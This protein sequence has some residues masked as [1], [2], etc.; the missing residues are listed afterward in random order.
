MRWA[1]E[2]ARPTRPTAGRGRG[3][4][5]ARWRSGLAWSGNGQV[6]A[7]VCA[8]EPRMCSERERVR[9]LTRGRSVQR[10]R[11]EKRSLLCQWALTQKRT[12]FGSRGASLL[13][14][15]QRDVAL[16]SL[17]ESELL[18]RGRAR[19]PRDCE[20]EGR[21]GAEGCQRALTRK[22]TLGGRGALEAF[23]LRL[24]E[25]FHELEQA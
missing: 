13:Q 3:P 1:R 10:K 23:D 7:C 16:E 2:H 11:E 9:F 12:L 25:D 21:V 19:F 24:R 17:G 22:R 18:L 14:R 6:C 5:G 4:R 15:L 20:H 8:C